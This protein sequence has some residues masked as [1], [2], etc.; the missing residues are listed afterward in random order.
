MVDERRES[1]L[2]QGARGAAS[3]IGL[4]LAVLLAGLAS[5]AVLTWA[6]T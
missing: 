2:R 1:R 6:L 4:G 3:V 5:S